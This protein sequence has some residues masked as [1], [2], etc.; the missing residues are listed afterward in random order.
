MPVERRRKHAGDSDFQAML[1]IMKK[2]CLGM[3]LEVVEQVEQG[4]PVNKR[5]F[6]GLCGFSLSRVLSQTHR[7]SLSNDCER[8]DLIESQYRKILLNIWSE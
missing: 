5:L 1:S 6:R 4:L 3:L 2:K 8:E 7:W